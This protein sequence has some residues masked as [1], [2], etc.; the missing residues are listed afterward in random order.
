MSEGEVQGSEF[1][2]HTE[3]QKRVKGLIFQSFRFSQGAPGC[4]Y[5]MLRWLTAEGHFDG[6]DFPEE[7]PD[8]LKELTFPLCCFDQLSCCFP[9]RTA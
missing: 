1:T 6:I 5:M 7:M 2:T 4:Q 9:K 8:Y 3:D